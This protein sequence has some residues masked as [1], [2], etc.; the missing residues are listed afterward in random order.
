MRKLR[1]S[2]E[3]TRDQVKDKRGKILAGLPPLPIVEQ[4]RVF[5]TR[6]FEP[7][8]KPA[9]PEWLRRL[10]YN[11]EDLAGAA[12]VFPDPDERR[13][14]LHPFSAQSPGHLSCFVELFEVASNDPLFDAGGDSPP[15][16]LDSGS[17]RK[18]FEFRMHF[19]VNTFFM[20]WELPQEELA[21]I[22]ILRNVGS[23]S[24]PVAKLMQR[25]QLL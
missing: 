13:F 7:P 16:S 9:N 23:L 2:K 6:R 19:D 11:R 20:H 4:V 21:S 22:Q 14:F 5:G 1:K 3:F 25:V 17:M 24:S 18:K 12:L 15:G 8:A 10:V